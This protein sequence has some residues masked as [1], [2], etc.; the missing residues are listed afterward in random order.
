MHTVTVKRR[1]NRYVSEFS[2]LPGKSFGPFDFAEMCRDLRVAALL[3]SREARDLVLD[4][5]KQGQA[6][7]QV[8]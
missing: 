1:G 2:Q 7:R 3:T 8:G 4:V 5:A 6:T